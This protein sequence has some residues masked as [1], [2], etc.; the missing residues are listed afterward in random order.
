MKSDE[1]S[2]AAPSPARSALRASDRNLRSAPGCDQRHV[3]FRRGGTDPPSPNLSPECRAGR[4]EGRGSVGTAPMKSDV[5]SRAAP[6]PARSALRASDRNLRSAPGCDQRHFLSRRGGTSPPSPNLSPECRA[7]RGEGRGSVG[8]APMKS[9][10]PSRAAPSPARSALRA[11]D[12]NLRSAPGCDQ[13]HFLSRRGGT[14]PPSPNL[15]PLLPERRSPMER[16]SPDRHRDHTGAYG[17]PLSRAARWS[18]GHHG[19]TWSRLVSQCRSGE[20]RSITS[21]AP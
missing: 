7:G 10:V 12:R 1:P 15:S 2:R 6:S 14:S 8:T 5:P 18:A 19:T 4:G 20:R 3:L 9:D 17:A 11:S 13:R 16:R 21:G